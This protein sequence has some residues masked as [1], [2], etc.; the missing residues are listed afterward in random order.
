MSDSHF[1]YMQR[2]SQ[3][4]LSLKESNLQQANQLIFEAFQLN[5]D[6]PET[7]NLL[8]I[9]SE[10]KGNGSVARK[11]Y[12]AA[13]ALDPTYEPASNNLERLCKLT[14]GLHNQEIDYGEVSVK[15]QKDIEIDKS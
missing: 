9:L 3:A 12:R 4:I 8:G 7:Q 14:W 1:V 13:Y 6:A 11:H 10:I 15:E 2:I 5:S